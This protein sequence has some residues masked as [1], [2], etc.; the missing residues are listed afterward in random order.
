MAKIVIIGGSFGGLTAAF[1]LKRLLGNK[2]DVTLLCDVDQ[3]VFVPSLPWISMGWRKPEDIT[4]PLEKILTPKGIKFIHEEA[5]G[6]DADKSKVITKT[7]EIPYDYLVIAS[8]PAL[9]F[10]SVP[11]LGPEGGYTECIFTLEQAIKTNKSWNKFLEKP[12]PVVIGAVQGVSCFGP[13]YEYAF[14]VDTELRKRKLRHKVPM[15]FVTSEPYIGHFGIGGLRTS[16]RMMEDE[17]ADREIKVI[18][19]QTVE[20]FV[21]DEVRLKDGIKLPFKIAMFA[22]PMAGVKAVFHLGNPK[23]FIPVDANYR[24]KNYKNI[25]SVGVAIVIAPPEQTPVPT[26]VPKTGFMTEHMA[27]DAAKSIAADILGKPS[28]ETEPVGALCIMDMGN[29]AA[30][31]KAYPVLPPRRVAELKVGINY[32]WAKQAF[33]KYYLWKIKRGLTQLP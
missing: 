18:A 28:P 6:V 29:K 17:F 21:P 12:G 13:A 26:G 14:E 27:K 32:K 33:E 22:P 1:E 31:M 16:R 15:T 7:Q 20:E 9:G 5:T 25:F 19:N 30:L 3:F 23:G 11:G 2:A 24:H 8:G 10:S 4:L